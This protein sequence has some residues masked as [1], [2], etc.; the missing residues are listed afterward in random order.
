[1]QLRDAVENDPRFEVV[2]VAGSR[3][4]G[5]RL[6]DRPV[7]NDWPEDFVVSF[8]ERGVCLTVHSA[9]QAERDAIVLFVTESL[10]RLGL[11]CDFEEE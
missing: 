8:D 9:T 7:R 1:M 3:V 10:G 11:T 4:V 2:H 6:A 5:A